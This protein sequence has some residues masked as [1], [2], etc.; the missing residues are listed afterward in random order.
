MLKCSPNFFGGRF[1]HRLHRG[2]SE[3][4]PKPPS[5]FPTPCLLLY[6]VGAGQVTT[7][8]TVCTKKSYLQPKRRS[9]KLSVYFEMEEAGGHHV[10]LGDT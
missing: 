4:A 2:H 3:R 10:I 1:A 7:P 6:G 8:K 5:S 9:K